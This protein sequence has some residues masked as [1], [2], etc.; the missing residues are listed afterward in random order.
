MLNAVIET[1]LP[2]LIQDLWHI[3]RGH[4]EAVD[5]VRPRGA[6]S[7]LSRR[8]DW[9][10][11]LVRI[12]VST[13]EPGSLSVDGSIL[14]EAWPWHLESPVEFALHGGCPG[15]SKVIRCLGFLHTVRGADYECLFVHAKLET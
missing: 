10:D 15:S 2:C 5:V 6:T 13:A 12:E 4:I 7:G 8:L 3:L 9:L 11:V 1:L 14:L